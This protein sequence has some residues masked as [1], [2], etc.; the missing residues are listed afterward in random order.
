M[1]RRLVASCLVFAGLWL[2]GA[3]LYARYNYEFSYATL[4]RAVDPLQSVWNGAGVLSI[5]I[6]VLF[7][8]LRPLTFNNSWGRVL[9]TLI[10]SACWFAYLARGAMHASGWFHANLLWMLAVLVGL[11]LLGVASGIGSF[12][13]RNQG[14]G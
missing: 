3:A 11:L 1:K 10:V 12:R 14:S 5:Q 13:H 2:A 4:S 9:I 8:L 7:A 6:L